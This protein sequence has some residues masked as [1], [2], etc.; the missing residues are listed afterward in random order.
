MDLRLLFAMF[1]TSLTYASAQ[2]RTPDPDSLMK[3]AAELAKSK[4]YQQARD[5]IREEVKKY[6]DY[7]DLQFAFLNYLYWDGKA[8]STLLMLDTLL[9][10]YPDEYHLYQIGINTCFNIDSTCFH[11]F[12][13]LAIKQFPD[14]TGRILGKTAFYYHEKKALQPAREMADSALK[15]DDADTALHNILFDYRISERY[16]LPGVG[17]L[18]YWIGAFPTWPRHQFLIEYQYKSDLGIVIPRF[19]IASRFNL[20]SWMGELEIYPKFGRNN[21]FY[22][23]VGFSDGILFPFWRFAAEPFFINNRNIELSIG[24]R[25]VDFGALKIHSIT[26]STGRYWGNNYANVRLIYTP[27]GNIGANISAVGS[28]KYFLNNPLHF[29]DVKIGYG[30]SP[31]S[32]YLD[33]DLAGTIF[34]R[35]FRFSAAYQFWLEKVILIRLGGYYEWINPSPLNPFNVFGLSVNIS[36]LL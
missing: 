7:K 20:Q 8:D 11:H 29:I 3:E 1:V 26:G 2:V 23:L 13:A 31:E 18:Y 4:N 22:G 35:A 16:R 21:Y 10:K 25:Y 6:P 14:S 36:F 32:E 27:F 17:Y 33:F 9:L 30:V 12:N 34:T 24:W 15:Y 28:Y 19:Q 5:L